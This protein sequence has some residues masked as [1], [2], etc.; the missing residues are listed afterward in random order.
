MGVSGGHLKGAVTQ[1]AA[2]WIE[3]N[4]GLHCP[5]SKGVPEVMESQVV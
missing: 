5:G 3:V 4:S 2:Q 1:D